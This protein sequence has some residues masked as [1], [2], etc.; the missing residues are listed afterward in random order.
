M[1]NWP[2]SQI[3]KTRDV[4]RFS[5]VGSFS[6]SQQGSGRDGEKQQSFPYGVILK[7]FWGFFEASLSKMSVSKCK[8]INV[9]NG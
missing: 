4:G 9:S 3:Y 8:S 1:N 5:R 7:K 6:Q 2:K